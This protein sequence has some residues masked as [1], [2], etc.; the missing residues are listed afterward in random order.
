MPPAVPADPTD[1]TA[2][3]TAAASSTSDYGALWALPTGFDYEY[4]ATDPLESATATSAQLDVSWKSDFDKAFGFAE[5][6][7]PLAGLFSDASQIGGYAEDILGVAKGLEDTA[8]TIEKIW[9]EL[10]DIHTWISIGWLL[11]GLYLLTWGIVIFT[12]GELIVGLGKALGG[13][14]SSAAKG[15]ASQAGRSAVARLLPEALA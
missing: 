2:T 7:N 13:G 4:P 6:L 10:S 5:D 12:A 11:L 9:D 15:A 3:T 1:P 8:T 14:A